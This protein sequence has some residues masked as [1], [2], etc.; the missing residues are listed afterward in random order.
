[1]AGQHGHDRAPRVDRAFRHEAPQAGQGSRA[2]RLA[3]DA[4]E[5]SE[6]PP[7]L[8]DLIIAHRLDAPA[9]LVA[10]TDGA[11]PRSRIADADRR[12]DPLPFGDPMTH[13]QL[14]P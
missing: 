14:P 13:H 1:M 5:T 9:R 4:L 11:V 8:E 10:R 3:E 6:I 7:R 2:G 12:R